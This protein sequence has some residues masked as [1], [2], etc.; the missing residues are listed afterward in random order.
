MISPLIRFYFIVVLTIFVLMFSVSRLP[1]LLNERHN[2]EIDALSL[3]NSL[4]SLSETQSVICQIAMG[5]NCENAVFIK[6]PD[7]YWSGFLNNQTSELF[8]FTNESGKVLICKLN[9]DHELLCINQ[10]KT[11]KSELSLNLVYIFYSL[12]FLSLFFL[13]KRLF[14]DVEVLRNTALADIKFDHFPEFTLSKRSYLQPLASSLEKLTTKIKQLNHFQAEMA[15]T[16]CHDIKTPLSRLKFISQLLDQQSTT[17][18]QQQMETN[19]AEIEENVYDYLRLAQ[20]DYAIEQPRVTSNNLDELIRCI[21]IPYLIDT[22]IR[23]KILNLSG[24]IFNG[25]K[26]LLAK[27]INNLI[28]NAYR[29][30]KS[31]ILISVTVNKDAGYLCIED[32]GAGWIE[33]ENLNA[34]IENTIQKNIVHHSIGLTIVQRVV[35]QHQGQVIL[36]PS[37]LGGALIKL[38]FPLTV[39]NCVKNL[40]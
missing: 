5:E 17:E 12:V 29:F 13:T 38:K 32:D 35:D 34:Q 19:I 40:Q 37:E 24:V 10:Q 9:V 33:S 16:V 2:P 4:Q 8:S 36:L 6:Y 30:A 7:H 23:V 22:N 28:A 21:L 11:N 18:T 20:N 3:I 25:D 15:E 1:Q 31:T 14:N 27:A 39:L 26:S